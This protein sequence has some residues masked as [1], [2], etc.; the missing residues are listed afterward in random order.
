MPR[1]LWWPLGGVLFLMS[2]VALYCQ[3]DMLGQSTINPQPFTL[4][5]VG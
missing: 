3:V 4:T 2:E 5:L 1:A